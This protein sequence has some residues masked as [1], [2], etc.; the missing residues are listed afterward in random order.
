MRWLHI[1]DIHFSYDAATVYLMREKLL[2]AVSKEV[3]QKPIDC[4]FITGDLRFGKNS[5]RTY[6]EDLSTFL[7]KL[8]AAAGV[9]KSR[10]FIVPGNHDVNR[11]AILKNNAEAIIRG[12]S[13]Q[14]GG[15]EPEYLDYI[16]L[17]RKP[18]YEIQ[19]QFA[20]APADAWHF[21]VPV[22]DFNI[23][24]LDTAIICG[25]DNEDGSL[26]V[27][28]ALLNKLSATV[29]CKK[30]GIALAHHDFDS[31]TIDERRYLEA[32]LKDMGV[33]LYLCGHK[34]VVDYFSQNHVRHEQPLWVA[35]AGTNM[36][37]SPNIDQVNMDFFLGDLDA[38]TQAGSL[39]AWK[40]SVQNSDWVLDTEFSCRIEKDN[41]TGRIQLGKTYHIPPAPTFCKE[42][43]L[44]KYQ[45]YLRSQCSEIE[46]NGLPTTT[47]DIKRRFK[48]QQLFV[49]LNFTRKVSGKEHEEQT[50]HYEDLFSR[51]GRSESA[52]HDLLK[53]I[54]EEIVEPP[55][56]IVNK[57]TQ[58]KDELNRDALFALEDLIPKEGTVRT[59]ILSS[60]GGGKTT[61]LKLL[62]CY[63]GLGN[64][65][66]QEVPL[67]ERSFF[68]LWLRCRD[69]SAG[70]RLPVWKIIHSIPEWMECNEPGF[71][72]AFERIV[73]EKQKTGELLLLIDGLDEIGSQE[74]RACFIDSVEQ[75]CQANPMVSMLLSSR[76]TGF[77]EVTEGKLGTFD[78]VT[79]ANLDDAAVQD[80]CRKWHKVVYGEAESVL[81]RANELA[82]TIIGNK[83]IRSLADN[84]LLLTTLLLVERRIGKLPTKRVTLYSE[85]VKVL[86]ETWNANALARYRVDLDEAEVQLA[87][88]AHN[89]MRDGSQ[90]IKKSK[91]IQLLQEVR[92]NHSDLV[93]EQYSI[94]TFLRNVEH[95][96][97]LL[98]QKGYETQENGSL[99]EVY[100][101]QH[102]TFQEYLAAKALARNC[103]Q[104]C[105]EEKQ[106]PLI[107]IPDLEGPNFRE[108]ILLTSAIDNK[109]ANGYVKSVLNEG[110][111]KSSYLRTMLLEL[112]SDEALI[113]QPVAERVLEFL[114]SDEI[115]Y[116]DLPYVTRILGGKHSGALRTYYE[117]M[118]EVRGNGSI[119]ILDTLEGRN[120]LGKLSNLLDNAAF[121]DEDKLLN[122]MQRLSAAAFVQD[123]LPQYSAEEL[124]AVKSSLLRCAESSHPKV[125][126]HLMEILR[127]ESDNLMESPDDYGVFL[128]CLVR[129]IAACETIDP[130]IGLLRKYCPL[131]HLS[132]V[133]VVLSDTAVAKVC[134]AF[135]ETNM[136]SGKRATLLLAVLLG[137]L[138]EEGL[139][140]ILRAYLDKRKTH[141]SPLELTEIAAYLRDTV[142]PAYPMEMIQLMDGFVLCELYESVRIRV[143]NVEI[144]EQV[145][146]DYFRPMKPLLA[147]YCMILAE[148]ITPAELKCLF[149]EKVKIYDSQLAK[150]YFGEPE[151][152]AT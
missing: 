52:N 119:F 84:P 40:W 66:Y 102:L 95:R 75:F 85:A 73:R 26:L 89:M 53:I 109:F 38:A 113:K 79:I 49:P 67:Q 7:S 48:L 133:P 60:P 47:D 42:E 70:A 21:C 125:L 105:D 98:V 30:P 152:V 118:D 80:L 146:G 100:E 6:P 122:V 111:A 64:T 1:S 131:P 142:Y 141:R 62:A 110:K 16:R 33:V 93:S 11:S 17:Q 9:D 94:S 150:E 23:I 108:V 135:R 86:L 37:Q 128:G 19:Q 76:P 92:R 13:T 134:N 132:H 50:T 101:F 83:R 34:H 14:K 149:A 69:F 2:T 112:L 36:D 115:L 140:S 137:E 20:N 88:V 27:D 78:V 35:V 51:L 82:D 151:A 104:G 29:D 10:T 15:I 12:Y 61:L 54:Q 39:T 56:E 117:K 4:L 107:G 147:H 45:E 126:K 25:R 143:A 120:E 129:Y 71:Q 41:Q 72:E 148:K 121:A 114:F 44:S 103:F 81:Q 5:P 123:Y 77:R 57:L 22:G 106:D 59:C 63:Y 58:S 74:D 145:E 130:I 90:R 68:P 96:S 46:L 97:A 43:V 18:F 24:G 32:R 99:E 65:V 3:C 31:L 116:S 91:L 8:Q 144:L 127:F 55:S 28:S 138:S 124:K 136:T 87:Y 139:R